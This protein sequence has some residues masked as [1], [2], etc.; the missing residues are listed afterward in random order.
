MI[1]QPANMQQRAYAILPFDALI[2]SLL[3]KNSCAMSCKRLRQSPEVMSRIA[4]TYLDQTGVQED[5][6]A[7][8]VQNAADDARRRAVRVVRLPHAQSDSDPERGR[9]AEQDSTENGDVIVLLG[10]T[11]E[12]Q[13]RTHTKTLEH[14]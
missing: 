3:N 5:A 14:F 12:R 9:D 7:E 11:D 4:G 6:A 13:P 10:K 8:R 2:I 1:P